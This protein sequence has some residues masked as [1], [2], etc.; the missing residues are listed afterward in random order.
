MVHYVPLGV[1]PLFQR[2]DLGLLTFLLE[3]FVAISGAA[4]D[5]PQE[6][7]AEL[8]IFFEQGSFFFNLFHQ[9]IQF[10]LWKGLG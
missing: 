5:L 6:I 2:V 10:D 3:G 8:E 1:A 4:M 7:L 9:E